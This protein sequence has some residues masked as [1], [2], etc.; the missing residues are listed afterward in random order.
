MGE[1][2]NRLV[3]ACILTDEEWTIYF[4]RGLKNYN[5]I[6]DQEGELLTDSEGNPK[7]FTS[8]EVVFQFDSKCECNTMISKVATSDIMDAKPN[9][10]GANIM[11][12][13]FFIILIL[14]LFSSP[15]YAKQHTYE[16]LVSDID[17]NLLEGVK[18]DYRITKGLDDI[19]RDSFITMGDGKMTASVYLNGYDNSQIEYTITKEGY[20]TSVGSSYIA[21][22]DADYKMDKK[23]ILYK[24]IDYLSPE[25]VSSQQGIILKDKVMVFIDLIRLHKFVSD[26]DLKPRAIKI[27]KFKD[28]DYLKFIF[29]S[30]TSYNS[31]RLDKYGVGKKLFDEVVRKVLNPLNEDIADP[32]LF[33]GYDLTVVGHMKNFADKYSEYLIGDAV[34]YRFLM[35]EKLVRQ[36]KDKDI[37]GQALLDGSIIL[38]D[39]E[40]IELKLQ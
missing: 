2:K 36:Y 39:D 21:M 33:Y 17:G 35:P 1:L 37:S 18:I 28:K 25:F 9:A 40:R 4:N 8:D 5:F 20:Y 26:A 10:K 29:I 31:L 30:S 15:I 27:E 7:R 13:S 34:N 23:I 6:H 22:L 32:K 3:N 16:I 11:K 38:M 24:R 12:V 19:K 14:V